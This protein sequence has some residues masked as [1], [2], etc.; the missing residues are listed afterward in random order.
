LIAPSY[1]DINRI[2]IG[3]D[4]G[5]IKTTTDGGVTWKDVTP[6]G[7]EALDES[8]QHGRRTFRCPYAYAAVNTHLDDMRRLACTMAAPFE[9]RSTQA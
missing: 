5:V 7:L 4:D 3:T 2:W 9:L 6:P 8:L 1:I